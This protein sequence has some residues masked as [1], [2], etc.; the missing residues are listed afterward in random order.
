M[1]FRLEFFPKAF[2]EKNQ[3]PSK[4]HAYWLL[5]YRTNRGKAGCT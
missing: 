2:E 5:L 3:A 1:D 4:A